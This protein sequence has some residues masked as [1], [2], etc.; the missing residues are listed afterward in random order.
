MLG[1]GGKEIR[2]GVVCFLYICVVCRFGTCN[3]Q[4]N[5]CVQYFSLNVSCGS[6]FCVCWN[7]MYLKKIKPMHG[8]VVITWRHSEN[9]SN[10]ENGKNLIFQSNVEASSYF[11]SAC[12]ENFCFIEELV[13]QK[14]ISC[15]VI[16]FFFVVDLI[17]CASW[18]I[19]SF[20]ILWIVFS[21]ERFYVLCII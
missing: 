5:D 2:S 20:C 12:C 13:Q 8:Q 16:F 6:F 15:D 10:C 19:P 21:T 14:T 7:Y 9:L 1:G 17:V 4:G 3:P 11:I 18:D